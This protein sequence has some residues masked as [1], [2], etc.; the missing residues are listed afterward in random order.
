MKIL[1]TGG[2]GYIGSHVALELVKQNYQVVIADN[3][4]N[5]SDKVIDRLRQ[6]SGV[7]PN[8]Y[9]VDLTDKDELYR[10]SS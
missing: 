9:K 5:S 7:C 4:S 6:I 8:F 3:L 10:V 1:V 2:C